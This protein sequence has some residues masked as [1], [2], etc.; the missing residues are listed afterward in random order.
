MTLRRIIGILLCIVGPS[1]VIP[2]KIYNIIPRGL[3]GIIKG[4]LILTSGLFFYPS[5]GISFSTHS[6]VFITASL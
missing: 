2:I 6:R 4:G 1:C 5:S 3:Q